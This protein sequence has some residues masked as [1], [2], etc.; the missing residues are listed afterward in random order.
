[1]SMVC[2][3]C[4]VPLQMEREGE[5]GY[6]TG[7][8][9]MRE[10]PLCQRCYRIKHYGE[11]T[12]VS[13]TEQDYRATVMRALERPAVVLYAV[14]LFDFNGSVVRGLQGL[15]NQHK[16]IVAANKFDLFPK[17]TNPD[18]VRGWLWREARRHEIEPAEIF[19]VSAQTGFGID[20][21]YERLIREARDKPVIVVGMA[22][23]GKSSMLNRILHLSDP[24]EGQLYTTS[25]FPG[26]T[27]GSVAFKIGK[28]GMTVID[29]PG[30][31]GTHRLQDRV[32]GSSLKQILPK[33]P[34]R[35]RG[36][37]LQP[38]QSLFLG[39]LARLDFVSGDPQSFVIYAANQLLVHR[40]KLENADELY[41]RQRGQL[42]TP[43]CSACDESLQQMTT[44]KMGFK[45][46][47]P[48]DIVIPGL[49]WIRLSGSA[50][51]L[52]LHT[53]V[54]IEAAVRP[55]LI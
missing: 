32:C 53:P 55:A 19:V 15:L 52:R 31:L 24:D 45:S 22:N 1:M 46:G 41:A 29:T 8:A 17:R 39:G 48:V 30:L 3:G 54:R 47:R 13:V 5:K 2:T 51:D 40:T 20:G 50:V 12:P 43:P 33:Q 23:V 37:Q 25:P 6:I 10:F 35:P 27:L 36:Y 38:G 44:K 28:T 11:I 49:G 14:D 18:R 7:D 26:T 34:L 9:F 16:V 21:L 4:G 42:L